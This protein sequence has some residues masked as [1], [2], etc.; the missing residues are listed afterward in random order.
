MKP[1]IPK[2]FNMKEN[3]G[4][5]FNVSKFLT[6]AMDRIPL[7]MVASRKMLNICRNSFFKYHKFARYELRFLQTL[8]FKYNITKVNLNEYFIDYYSDIRRDMTAKDEI[9]WKEYIRS[10]EYLNLLM[11]FKERNESKENS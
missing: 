5:E 8:N 10:K 6:R 11:D 7:S 4:P 1:F 2:E 3:N 9:K